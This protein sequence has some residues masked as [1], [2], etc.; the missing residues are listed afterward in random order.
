MSLEEYKK[1]KEERLKEGEEAKAH[2]K[3]VNLP[4][5]RTMEV[6]TDDVRARIAEMKKEKEKP[7]HD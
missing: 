4:G 6:Q 2:Y 3:S 1:L 7:N 5:D